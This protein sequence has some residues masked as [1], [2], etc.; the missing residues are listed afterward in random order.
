MYSSFSSG[1]SSSKPGGGSA[2]CR[3]LKYIVM[4]PYNRGYPSRVL[5]RAQ[6][7][8]RGS[9]D[10]LAT[11]VV[12]ANLDLID[13]LRVVL[14]PSTLTPQRVLRR[15]RVSRAVVPQPRGPAA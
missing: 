5:R 14:P 2:G 1:E 6:P 9:W 15:L 7:Y 4:Q 10:T 3:M 13:T 11:P 8:L 12:R